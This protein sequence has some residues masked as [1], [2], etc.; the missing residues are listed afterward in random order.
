M[1][2]METTG[3]DTISS[4]SL[5]FKPFVQNNDEQPVE[6]KSTTD[7]AFIGKLPFPP[8]I[9]TTDLIVHKK[10][11]DMPSRSPNAFMI[12][13]KAYVDELHRQGHYLPMTTASSMASASW[14]VEC[15]E[16]KSEYRRL[17]NEAK[18][19]HLK[20]YSNKISRR[21]RQPRSKTQNRVVKQVQVPPTT[22]LQVIPQ[23]QH[24]EHDSSSVATSVSTPL[25]DSSSIKI[26]DLTNTQE[27]VYNNMASIN[28]SPSIYTPTYEFNE[29]NLDGSLPSEFQLVDQDNYYDY[30]Y[31]QSNANLFYGQLMSDL[32]YQFYDQACENSQPLVYDD[33]IHYPYSYFS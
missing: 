5:D 28:L 33:T 24:S 22:W 31:F 2:I 25:S 10:N 16:V 32:Q 26:E 30:N 17:A 29:F 1:L 18:S 19:R 15:E 3:K 27:I 14:K 20:L 23:Y 12:Y 13:R 9:S 6:L 21:K 4:N 11:G 8:K 7:G